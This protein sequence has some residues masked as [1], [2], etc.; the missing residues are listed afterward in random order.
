MHKC[1]ISTFFALILTAPGVAAYGPADA[2]NDAGSTLAGPTHAVLAFAVYGFY[3]RGETDGYHYKL[4]FEDGTWSVYEDGDGDYAR[5][6]DEAE[7][8]AIPVPPARVH[9]NVTD[10]V[11]VVSGDHRAKL[12]I[13]DASEGLVDGLARGLRCNG[14]L[15]SD[16]AGDFSEIADGSSPAGTSLP[17]LP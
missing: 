9:G 16:G 13:E 14:D 12:C 5:D 6:A 10:H 17:V 7:L 1:V 2:A 4:A 15:D 11:L 8:A 3:G